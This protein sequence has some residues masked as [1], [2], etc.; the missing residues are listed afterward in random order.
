MA[1]DTASPSE[2]AINKL[3]G[4]KLHTK[5]TCAESGEAIEVRRCTCSGTSL[6]T[7]NWQT[8]ISTY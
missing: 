8:L 4:V 6:S 7:T 3:F 2:S 1:Q 5:L